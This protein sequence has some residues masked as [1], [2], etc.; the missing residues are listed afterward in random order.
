M[1]KNQSLTNKPMPAILQLLT[2]TQT[3]PQIE[4]RK[5]P[6]QMLEPHIAITPYV[7]V[8]RF[9]RD[10]YL[11]APAS[12]AQDQLTQLRAEADRLLHLCSAQSERY[13]RRIEWETDHL[14]EEHKKGMDKV[15]RKL[16]PVSDLSPIFADF[17]YHPGIV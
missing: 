2:P 14:A 6:T 11:T 1:N 3:L 12:F 16:E 10:G 9:W 5:M 13:I 17:A 4:E 8:D 15:I 7:D